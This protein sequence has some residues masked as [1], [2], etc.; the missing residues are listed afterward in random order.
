MK[1]N[2]LITVLTILISTLFIAAMPTDKEGSIYSDTVRLHILANSDELE[3]QELKLKLRDAI[4]TEYG[5]NLS[6]FD[7][8]EDAKSKLSEKLSEIEIF[9]KDMIKTLGYDYDV[10]VTLSEEWYDTRDYGDFSLPAGIYASLRIIIG[11][12]AGQNWW[13][14]M[15]PPLC[16]DASLADSPTYSVEEE[17]LIKR[18][19]SVK[20][21]ILELVSKIGKDQS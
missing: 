12:G 18:K 10:S 21:K 5:E 19:Y 4:L 11:E 9:S 16:L 14:V 15:F 7:S 1:K 8:A 17:L 3:D 20:F 13:C 2:I 6:V